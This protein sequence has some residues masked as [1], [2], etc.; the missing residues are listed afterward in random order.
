MFERKNDNLSM[1]RLDKLEFIGALNS[2]LQNY[3]S[4]YSLGKRL[5]INEDSAHTENSGIRIHD[6]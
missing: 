3:L 2:K 6:G 5:Y 4:R 1:Q